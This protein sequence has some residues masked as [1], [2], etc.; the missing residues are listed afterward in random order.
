MLS[1][2]LRLHFGIMSQ[3]K[4]WVLLRAAELAYITIT[5]TVLWS[6]IHIGPLQL[7]LLLLSSM[8]QHEANRVHTTLIVITTYKNGSISA[9]TVG[10]NYL[11]S[12]KGPKV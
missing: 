5:T 9:D 12:Q 1:G 11:V 8:Q 10:G 3:I 4:P 2:H 6:L 7:F